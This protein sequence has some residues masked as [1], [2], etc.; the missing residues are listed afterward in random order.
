[1]DGG[2]DE[3]RSAGHQGEASVQPGDQR[4]PPIDDIRGRVAYLGEL[5]RVQVAVV[6]MGVTA[7]VRGTVCCPARRVEMNRRRR[8]RYV[9]P[10]DGP[11]ELLASEWTDGTVLVR[12]RAYASRS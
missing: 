12:A 10:F 1:I 5:P 4:P 11:A 6:E 9:G 2:R 7:G 8:H 3:A